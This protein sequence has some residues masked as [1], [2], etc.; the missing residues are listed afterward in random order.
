M[1]VEVLEERATFYHITYR[2]KCNQD[3]ICQEYFIHYSL[4]SNDRIRRDKLFP[5][6][7]VLGISA[8]LVN[9]CKLTLADTKSQLKIDDE[10]PS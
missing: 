3:G 2:C 10:N 4:F 7:Y 5:A 8:K 9:M 6:M 1:S